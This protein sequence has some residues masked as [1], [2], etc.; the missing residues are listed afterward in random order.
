MTGPTRRLTWS[1]GGGTQSV[2]IAVLVAQRITLEVTDVRVERV[3]DIS[4][5]D[6]IAEGITHHDGLDVGH[7]GFRY[8]TD[9]PVYATAKAAYAALWDKINR[10]RGYGLDVNPWAWV[11]EFERLEAAS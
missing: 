11:V 10:K 8:S 3:Q 2:A 1:Y 6:V 4:E 5:A 9:S 7:S